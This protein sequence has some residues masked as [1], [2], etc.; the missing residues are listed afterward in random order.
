MYTFCKKLL[1]LSLK[2]NKT[3]RWLTI[4][5]DIKATVDLPCEV[6][7]LHNPIPIGTHRKGHRPM[8]LQLEK[9]IPTNLNAITL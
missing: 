1:I 9:S 2:D 8:E 3:L 6:F 7:I 4:K 5:P